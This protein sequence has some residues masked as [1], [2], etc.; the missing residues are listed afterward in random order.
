[1]SEFLKSGE[2]HEL[3]EKGLIN[4]SYRDFENYRQRMRSRREY[5]R[6]IGEV[7]K[8]DANFNQQFTIEAKR[9]RRIGI[10]CTILEYEIL[11]RYDYPQYM[12]EEYERWEGELTKGLDHLRMWQAGQLPDNWRQEYK[13]GVILASFFG[14]L[15]SKNGNMLREYGIED[16]TDKTQAILDYICRR[17]QTGDYYCEFAKERGIT[18]EKIQEIADEIGLAE[19]V[20]GESASSEEIE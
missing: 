18:T 4:L 19:M 14:H 5:L 12:G 17:F 7:E 6:S 3:T 20:S 11:S 1:M 10:P 8:A 2:G 15:V 13:A 9:E 16:E